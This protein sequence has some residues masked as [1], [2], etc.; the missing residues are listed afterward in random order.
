[1]EAA[2]ATVLS[3]R[4]VF[5]HP[6]ADAVLLAG[7][8][9]L[10][11]GTRSAMRRMAP[12]P[13]EILRA[14]GGLICPGFHD[15]HIHLG[16]Y[17]ERLAEL[18][19]RGRDLEQVQRALGEAAR[20]RDPAAWI[21]GGGLDPSVTRA[22][23][24][25]PADRL[26]AAAPGRLV[27]LRTH[28]YHGVH[29]SRSALRALDAVISAAPA[30]HVERGSDG[31]PTGVLLESA[32]LAAEARASDLS[33]ADVEAGILTCV[34]D[35]VAH[36]ITA[37]HEMSGDRDRAALARLDVSGRLPI[38]VFATLGPSEERL[39]P[40]SGDRLHRDRLQIVALKAFLD[41]S[42]GS[43]S[44]HLLEPYEGADDGH[45]GLVVT[46]AATARAAVER[47]A[48]L[49]LPSWLH[50]IGDAAVRTALDLL[51]AVSVPGSVPHRVEHAQMIHDDDLPRFAETG[52]VASLQP[53]HL[54][55]DAALA[56]RHWGR[57][58]REAFPL[59]RLLDLGA[60]VALGSDAPVESPDPIEGIRAAVDRRGEDG[61]RLAPDEAITVA[62]AIAGYTIGAARAVGRQADLGR[63]APGATGNLT[64]LSHDVVS[65]PANLADC[66][67]AATVVSGRVLHSEGLGR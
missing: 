64:V 29:V 60:A 34:A 25:T 63:I 17:A 65:D 55:V 12:T 45:C 8:R 54:R 50:A 3:A 35:L 22:P 51:Q 11:V 61:S 40:P 43:R 30:A 1:M 41:G 36:G 28:D 57:R 7:D 9:I 14:E 27:L 18:E 44:A 21:V 38:D 52:V 31:K 59:R 23:G 26:E 67:I 49:G 48:R 58:A 24:A 66:R 39:P 4:A 32:S 33:D 19:L 47:A 2:S 6:G 42:L 13:P 56:R 15:A 20:T 16:L 37:V 53:I 5:G 46:D 10:A 62:E